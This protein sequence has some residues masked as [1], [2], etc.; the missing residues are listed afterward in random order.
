M[1]LGMASN[2]PGNFGQFR[3]IGSDE[4][5]QTEST[6]GP[7]LNASLT[8][9]AGESL[10]VS[11]PAVCLNFGLPT[12]TSRDR[13]KLMDVDAYS[14]D[15]RVRKSLRSLC[16]IG[17]SQGVAQAVMWRVC[18]DLTFEA[19][20]TQA[21]RVVNEHEIA[22]AARFIAALDESTG[23]SLVDTKALTEGRIFVN[24]QGEGGMADKAHKLN[25]QVGKFPLLG[26][27][28]RVVDDGEL[29]SAPSALFIKVVLTEG[30]TGETSGRIFVSYSSG[31]DQWL[32]LG[33]S[34]FQDTSPVDVLDG[35]AMSQIIDH[36]I[37]LAFVAVKPARRVV[38]TTMLKVDNHLPFTLANVTVKAGASAGSPSVCF[39]GLG[40]GP[41]R[42]SVLA[43]QASSAMVERVELNGL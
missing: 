8:V 22:L 2:R 3:H 17:T 25:N 38:G 26:L 1:G 43:I 31:V 36:S 35:K 42:S 19:M 9:P 11:I 24:I 40:V 7:L 28:V 32:P 10:D 23:S 18:N 4:G 20:T 12:P 41:A 6:S 16:L 5:R 29:A 30:K 27:P 39:H 34:K 13:F 33:K 21:G 15:T 37:G 14:A